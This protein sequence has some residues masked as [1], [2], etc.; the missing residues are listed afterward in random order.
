MKKKYKT[1]ALTVLIG[2]ILTCLIVFHFIGI[3]PDIVA[4]V[5]SQVY[6]TINYPTKGF[7]FKSGEYSYGFGDYFVKYENEDGETVG[8][9][10]LPEK[11][12]I[13]VRQDTKKFN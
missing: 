10:M 7:K 8:L 5:S 4:R 12:P 1:T 9:M 2:I 3:L 13:I 11:F 6:I